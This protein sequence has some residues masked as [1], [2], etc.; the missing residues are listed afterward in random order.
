MTKTDFDRAMR[1]LAKELKEIVSSY[2]S[3]VRVAVKGMKW[4]VG[5]TWRYLHSVSK[6]ISELPPKGR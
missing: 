6:P 3:P 2:F 1:A 4:A 5:R